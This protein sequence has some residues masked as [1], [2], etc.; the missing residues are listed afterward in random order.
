MVAVPTIYHERIG[1]ALADAGVHA[2][3][4]K[5]LAQDTAVRRPGCRGLR[6]RATSSAPSVTSSGTTRRCNRLARG[7]EAGDLGEVYQVITRRQGPFPARIADVGVVKDLG[8]HDI[9][10]TAG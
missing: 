1:L 8:T 3:I 10:L 4:E 7:I 2:L 9:D 5:P 6:G